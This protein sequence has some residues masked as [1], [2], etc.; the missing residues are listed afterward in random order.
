MQATMEKKMRK[1]KS[2]RILIQ[3]RRIKRLGITEVIKM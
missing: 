1:M 2:K 3:V